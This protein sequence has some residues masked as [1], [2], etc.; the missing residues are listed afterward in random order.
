VPARDLDDWIALN[1]L[2]PLGPLRVRRLLERVGDPREIAYRLPLRALAGMARIGPRGIAEIERA[3]R[4]L[5]RRVRRER[6][7]AEKLGLRLLPWNDADYPAALRTL[8]DPP[9]L[10]YLK[11]DLPP[12]IVRIAVVGS[13][14]ATAY[15]KRVATGLGL[16][17]AARGVEVVSGGARGVDT[18]CHRGAL[19]EGGRTL[20]VLG[21]GLAEPYPRENGGLFDR[22]AESGALISEFPLDHPPRKENF[23]RRNRLISGLSAAV[24]VVEATE[25]SGSLVTA[26]HALEQGREVLAIPGPV[27]SDR[28]TGCHR[29]IQQG[30]RLVQNVDDVISDLS[31]MYRDALPRPRGQAAGPGAAGDARGTPDEEAILALLDAVEP[32]HLDELADRAPFGIA[33][34]QAALF[35]LELRGRAEI[36]PGRYYRSRG[37]GPE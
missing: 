37:S 6:R 24:V 27:S 28:S 21:S 34:L 31:P 1:L 36:L 13:R 25:R 8:P 10:L 2:L 29:L 12:A 19:D 32:T 15:G 23:P 4:D 30:A 9:P 11:G 18:C 17:L 20:A 16:G 26:G 22:I 5:G 33:R 35:G 14:H 7:R 3:R